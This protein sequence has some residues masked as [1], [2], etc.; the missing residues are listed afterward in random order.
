M[1]LE[2]KCNELSTNICSDLASEFP[3]YIYWSPDKQVL[4]HSTSI[5]ELFN[6]VRIPK[7]LKVSD[8]G[9]SFLLQSG[10]VPPPKTG[11][12][13][14]YILGIGDI[15]KIATVNGKIEVTFKHKFPFMNINRLHTDEI[16]AIQI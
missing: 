6:D 13:N 7:P 14:I 1:I 5:N 12:Q 2:Y 9:I 3:V 8:E 15:A 4:L 11:Y 16:F 10:V